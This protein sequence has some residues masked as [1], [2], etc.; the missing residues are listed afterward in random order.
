MVTGLNFRIMGAELRIFRYICF[1]YLNVIGKPWAAVI[2]RIFTTLN[3]L[4]QNNMKTIYLLIAAAFACLTGN[5]NAQAPDWLWAKAMG[6]AGQDYGFSITT[7]ASGNVYTTGTFIGTVDFDPDSSGTFNL[8]SA[9]AEDIFI[10]K[11]DGS[12]NFVW[13]KAMGGT[14]QDVGLFIA[15]DASG[16]V[17]TT[18]YFSGTADFDPDSSVSFNFI[19]V[20][21]N[22]IFVCKLDASGNFVWAKAMS[23]AGFEHGFS[24]AID[25][26]GSGAVYTTGEFQA[27]VDFDP[28]VGVFSL[29]S[30]GGFNSFISKL[31]TSGNFVWAKA[32]GG[33]GN[34]RGKFIAIDISGN[35]Y[36]TGWFD[37]T[38]DFDPGAG[39][40]NLTASATFP[41]EIFISKLD[42]SGNF[43]WAKAM[44]GPAN[45]AAY[46]IAI[47]ASGNVYTTGNF[48]SGTA[49]FDPDSAGVFNLTSAGLYDIFISKLDSS[50]NFVWAKAMGGGDND[51]GSSVAIDIS[52]NVYTT[53]SFVG[54]V[55]FDPDSAGTFNLTAVNQ[56][57]IFL[58]KLDGS[59]NFVWAKAMDGA[60]VD[61]GRCIAIGSS[62]NVFITGVFTSPSIAFGAITLTNATTAG[63]NDIFIAKLDT[64]TGVGINEIENSANGILVF[65]NPATNYLT[66]T[67]GSSS[68]KV[69]VTITDITGK[70]IYSAVATETR[71]IEVSN[72]DFAQGIYIIQI[73]AEDFIETKKLIV[74]K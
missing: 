8:T 53:G 45:D 13:A 5:V 40:F 57:G 46:S 52:G 68:K 55:D 44:G 61:E 74:V 34:V 43:V 66:I 4:K 36:T 14:V 7:D 22:D 42:S 3:N 31:D 73:R 64:A 37:Q 67:L 69:E 60:I 50:G 1:A 20:G 62:G 41:P 51:G 28:G 35:I 54:T 26:A 32:M 72:I 70:I 33:G 59:G 30:A 12:G 65:P 63:T 58:S 16:N 18:G 48:N 19:S 49:D 71:K 11:S 6:G 24:I 21:A 47:D 38:A 25:P 39:T 56:S 29:T 15:V 2:T 23:G 17:Y 10:S 27:T 9:G